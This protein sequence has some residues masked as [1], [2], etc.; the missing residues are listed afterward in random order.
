MLTSLLR[1]PCSYTHCLNMQKL[2]TV[3]YVVTQLMW[4]VFNFSICLPAHWNGSTYPIKLIYL[5]RISSYS[6]GNY[7]C[8]PSSVN[9]FL[10]RPKKETVRVPWNFPLRHVQHQLSVPDFASFARQNL[11]RKA[12][13]RG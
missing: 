5:P 1:R 2:Y 3:M 6:T 12:W 4:G 8:S 13:V 10:S 7:C 9:A 11:E